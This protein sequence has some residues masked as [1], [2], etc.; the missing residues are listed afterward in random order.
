MII[1][2][3]LITNQ[4]NF[5][6]PEK[7][8]NKNKKDEIIKILND[9]TKKI[10]NEK[11]QNINCDEF[12][13]FINKNIELDEYNKLRK[14]SEEIVFSLFEKIK[15]LTEENTPKMLKTEKEIKHV[16]CVCLVDAIETF[17]KK[18][19]RQIHYR[20]FNPIS[21]IDYDLNF[22][23]NMTIEK[24]EKLLLLSGIIFKNVYGYHD[25]YDYY[26]KELNKTAK[27]KQIKV[28]KEHYLNTYFDVFCRNLA[29]D[30]ESRYNSLTLND[31]FI[32]THELKQKSLEA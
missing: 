5:L 12:L 14:I 9:E 31:I 30:R 7:E 3:N 11:Y 4:L 27:Q 24:K 22:I 17:F 1:L 26:K 32:L 28:N 18:S 23:Q 16:I 15:H 29:E 19:W 13:Q 2:N 20:Q 25:N 6:F 10:I 8:F 21:L